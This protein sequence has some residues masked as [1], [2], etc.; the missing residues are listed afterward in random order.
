MQDRNTQYAYTSDV[1]EVLTFKTF[2]GFKKQAA[3][4]TA[5]R[6]KLARQLFSISQASASTTTYS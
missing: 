2:K 5:N 1:E 3:C 4:E 6:N